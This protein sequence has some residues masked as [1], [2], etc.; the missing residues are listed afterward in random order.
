MSAVRVRLSPTRE[1]SRYKDITRFFLGVKQC[2]TT[3]QAL[4]LPEK[5][6]IQPHLPVRLPC[7]D[8]TPV[9]S[10]AFGIPLLAVKVTTSGMA[11]SHSV[12]GGV[13]KARERIHRRMADRR[14]LAIP[15]S[16]RRHVCRP[17]HKGHDDLTSSSPSSGLSPAVCSGHAPPVSAFP[18]APLSFKRIRGMSSP[19]KLEFR[20]THIVLLSLYLFSSSVRS[21]LV[22]FVSRVCRVILLAYFQRGTVAESD[23]LA[24]ANLSRLGESYR[25]SPKY[26]FAKGRPGDP[27]YAKGARLSEGPPRLGVTFLPERDAGREMVRNSLESL[28]ETFKVALQWSGRNSK[29][30][31]SG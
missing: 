23:R 1:L 14:L 8:F 17:G 30:P 5:E 22:R 25:G 20:V 13:Y 16:C 28:G 4:A 19:G 15:A 9:T 29:A 27:L 11:S 21:V 24:Q 10:P 2:Q 26:F 3:Q 7:Y 6:V 12:T 31:V 18:K